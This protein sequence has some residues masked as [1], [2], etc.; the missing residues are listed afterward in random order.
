MGTTSAVEESPPPSSEWSVESEVELLSPHT[1]GSLSPTRLLA[2]STRVRRT[3]VDRRPERMR[4]VGIV[5]GGL[6]IVVMGMSLGV[7]AVV[8]AGIR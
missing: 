4:T 8:A 3:R 6:L 2:A 1:V 5:V 7:L